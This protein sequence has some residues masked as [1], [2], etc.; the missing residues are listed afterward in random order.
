MGN[1]CKSTL[2][3][4]EASTHRPI[5]TS[6]TMGLFCVVFVLLALQMKMQSADA[7]SF[8]NL[9]EEAET[10]LESRGTCLRYYSECGGDKGACCD[11]CHC[12]YRTHQGERQLKRRIRC[13]V[14]GQLCK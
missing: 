2:L 3:K 13:N 6:A 9:E 1:V 7:A 4:I 11:G 14:I 10:K 8:G 12:R 5:D